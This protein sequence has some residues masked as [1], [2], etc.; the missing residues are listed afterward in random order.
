M[1]EKSAASAKDLKNPRRRIMRKLSAKAHDCSRKSCA[2]AESLRKIYLT[3]ADS[4]G[5]FLAD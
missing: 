5:D 3:L 1:S 4:P 2:F